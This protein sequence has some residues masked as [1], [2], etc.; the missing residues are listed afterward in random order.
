MISDIMS[1]GASNQQID[2]E[3]R[4][5]CVIQVRMWPIENK[6]PLSTTGLMDV[7]KMARSWR[8]RAPDRPE[9]K[10]TIVMSQ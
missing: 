5:C 8:R 7:I 6:V 9:T 2:T 3:V 1:S 10:P 4:I